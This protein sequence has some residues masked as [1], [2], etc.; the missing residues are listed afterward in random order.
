M[1]ALTSSKL[2]EVEEFYLREALPPITAYLFNNVAES[3][4]LEWEAWIKC[5]KTLHHDFTEFKTAQ[6]L[7][8]R[9]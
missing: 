3:A 2:W 1:A 6:A 9:H 8:S 4:T 5:A 7:W